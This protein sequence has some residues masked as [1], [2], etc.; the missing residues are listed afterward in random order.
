MTAA[1]VVH[2][3][4]AGPAWAPATDSAVRA[5]VGVVR[6]P[7]TAVVVVQKLAAAPTWELESDGAV[8]AGHCRRWHGALGGRIVSAAA[9]AVAAVASIRAEA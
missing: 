3:L 5:V 1:V 9:A 4:T 7:Q 2:K 6:P 8:L